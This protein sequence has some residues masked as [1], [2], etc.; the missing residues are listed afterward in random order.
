MVSGQ[1]FGSSV[2]S[3]A[4]ITSMCSVQHFPGGHSL[5]LA[6]GSFLYPHPPL[7]LNFVTD[8]SV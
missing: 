3:L 7:P 2:I 6:F 5:H 1:S 4:R 8:K